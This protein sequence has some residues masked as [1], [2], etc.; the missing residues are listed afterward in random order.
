MAQADMFGV[1]GKL[2]AQ[3]GR[4]DE[5]V[6]LIGEGA[7]ALGD[8]SGF[9]AYSVIATLEEPDTI[10]LTEAWTDKAAHDTWIGSEPGRMVAQKIAALLAEPPTAWSGDLLFA[11]GR[12]TAALPGAAQEN[13][14]QSGAAYKPSCGGLEG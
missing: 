8:A 11:R 14:D 3:P 12:G 6:D 4:R 13:A 9:I 7:R 1:C 10:L 2:T 5:V